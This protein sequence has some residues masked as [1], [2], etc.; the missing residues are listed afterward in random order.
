MALSIHNKLKKGNICS[1]ELLALALLIDNKQ[2]MLTHNKNK[3][4]DGCWRTY[5]K[6]TALIVRNVRKT[7]TLTRN[8]YALT[9]NTM[10]GV[11]WTI[12]CPNFHV[13]RR[14]KTLNEESPWNLRERNYHDQDHRGIRVLRIQDLVR[15][16]HFR[17]C[18]TRGTCT[19]FGIK[20]TVP[21]HVVVGDDHF[22]DT[23]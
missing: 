15:G 21:T 20:C 13:R 16:P 22:W 17:E 10:V 5:V 6:Q 14:M 19:L 9:S 7:S 12:D 4:A 11:T 8:R 1:Q 23:Q 3:H 2:G 18:Y